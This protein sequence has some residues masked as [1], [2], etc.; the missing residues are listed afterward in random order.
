MR[1]CLIGAMHPC[2][3]P[4]V[5]READA[6]VSE[7]HEVR[8]VAP[9]VMPHLE[10]RD[11]ELM[12]RRSWRLDQVRLSPVTWQGRLRGFRA[13]L[14]R[15]GARKLFDVHPSAGLAACAYSLALPELMKLACSEPAD[16]FIAHTQ[17]SLP[18]AASAACKYG[19]KLGFDCEDLLAL[20]PSDDPV[21][22]RAIEQRYIRECDYISVT[23]RAM[24]AE[25]K[26]EYGLEPIILYNVFP[27]SLARGIAPP[28]SRPADGPLRLH[29]FSQTAGPGRGIEDALEA[30]GVLGGGIELHIRATSIPGY[31][32][33]MC[34]AAERMG[35]PIYFHPS[36]PHDQ[37]IASLAEF[38][39]GLALERPESRNYA[40]TVTNKAFSYMLAGLAVAATDTPGQREAMAHAPAAGFIYPAGDV[41]ALAAKLRA[42]RD[43]RTKVRAAQQAAWDAARSQFCW[44]I[45]QDKFLRAVDAVRAERALGIAR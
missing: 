23:S 29:W 28:A 8:V 33:D 43:D 20:A 32:A 18:I 3:N 7:G 39:V 24:A 37:L 41:P 9:S 26:R 35:V 34:A 13:R 17:P 2:H 21:L 15:H 14:R 27:L 45:E 16:W 40:I 42:W 25:V 30:A 11:A 6:L 36:I 10:R 38:D 19:A 44:E 22:V 12:A 31:Q 5:V 1:F 4:R